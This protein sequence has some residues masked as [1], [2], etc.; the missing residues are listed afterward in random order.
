MGTTSEG[1]ALVRQGLAVPQKVR[2]VLLAEKDGA[3]FVA[4][5]EQ[6][7][8][9][10]FPGIGELFSLWGADETFQLPDAGTEPAMDGTFPPVGGFR[11]FMTRFAPREGVELSGGDMPHSDM[12]SASD[13]HSSDTVDVNMVLSGALDCLLSDGSRVTLQAG[14]SIVL[15]GAAHAWENN[16]T[17]EAVMLFFLVGANRA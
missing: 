10:P 4:Q 13:L 2:R 3:S 1:S 8:A 12:P 7:E 9:S 16:S 5:E 14:D 17:D 15:N 6:L 11:V